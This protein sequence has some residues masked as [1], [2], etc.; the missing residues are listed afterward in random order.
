MTE[1]KPDE[2]HDALARTLTDA[3]KLIEVGWIAYRQ[4]VLPRDCSQVQ[5]D[6]TRMGF[7]AGAQHLFGSIMSILE[8][9]AEPTEADLKRMD[10]IYAELDEFGKSL[11]RRLS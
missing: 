8:P 3:G 6:E 9:G 5:L 10:L 1:P 11:V 4:H 2:I 7:F